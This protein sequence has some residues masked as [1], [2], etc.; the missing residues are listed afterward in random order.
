[1]QE[2]WKVSTTSGSKRGKKAT[3]VPE[4]TAASSHPTKESEASLKITAHAAS[5]YTAGGNQASAH[6]DSLK[7]SFS[8]Y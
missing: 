8:K 6:G 3:S 5:P 2:V 7:V 4:T 1:M